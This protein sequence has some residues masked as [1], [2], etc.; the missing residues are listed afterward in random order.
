VVPERVRFDVAGVKLS[1]AGVEI[2]YVENAF[3]PRY[4]W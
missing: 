1:P 3:V 4:A 2:D